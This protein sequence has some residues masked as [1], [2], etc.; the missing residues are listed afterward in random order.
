MLLAV[1]DV[2]TSAFMSV[3]TPVQ[4]SWQTRVTLS[5]KLATACLFGM[6][7]AIIVI[8]RTCIYTLPKNCS[9]PV[10]SFLK[11]SRSHGVGKRRDCFLK[12]PLLLPENAPSWLNMAP[13]ITQQRMYVCT[14]VRMYVCTYVC[15][16]VC[17]YDY[18]CMYRPSS[19]LSG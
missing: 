9:I 16:Y 17:M 6:K 11:Q 7:D 15:M 13:R 12:N 3:E 5:A 19:L 10:L 14:Y 18:V 4:P 1:L 2:V 8:A